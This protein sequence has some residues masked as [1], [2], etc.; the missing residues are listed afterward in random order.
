MDGEISVKLPQNLWESVSNL[1]LVLQPKTATLQLQT[2]QLTAGIIWIIYDNHARAKL[3]DL[4][5]QVT[6]QFHESWMKMK[7]AINAIGSTASKALATEIDK[8]GKI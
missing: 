3:C 7:H 2:E 5:V 1:K 6:G 4:C 8:R